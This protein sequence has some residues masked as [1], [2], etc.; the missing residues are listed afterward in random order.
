[1][2]LSINQTSRGNASRT[3]RKKNKKT[4]VFDLPLDKALIKTYVGKT[5]LAV[6]MKKY[7]GSSIDLFP[8]GHNPNAEYKDLWLLRATSRNKITIQ[9]LANDMIDR[10]NHIVEIVKQIHSHIH[11]K[12]Q[13]DGNCECHHECE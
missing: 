2:S 8:P 1:M 4:Y 5:Q 12:E 11:D 3:N 9:S 10:Y 13:C 7:K 6:M